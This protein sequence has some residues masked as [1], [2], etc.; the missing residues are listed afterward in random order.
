MVLKNIVFQLIKILSWIFIT[1]LTLL[2]IHNALQYFRYDTSYGILGESSAKDSAFYL[3]LF[4][5]HLLAGTLC[6]LTPLFQF[7]IRVKAKT[8][9]LHRFIGHV[10]TWSTLI[11]VVPTGLYIALFAKG[12]T[13]TQIGFIA[14][15]LLAGVFTWLGYQAGRK[16]NI[17]A[18][19][20]WMMRS[21]GAVSIV[22]TFRLLHVVFFHLRLPY[23]T[24]YEA[25][26]WIGIV[27][28]LLLVELLIERI[29]SKRKRSLNP[30]LS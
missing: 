15:G 3:S 5:T 22:L 14:Q 23:Q 18:H 2:L 16:R 20:K 25:S 6:I 27:L 19:I 21:Y 24:N 7:L 11:I 28:N 1:L 26:Q 9:T 4:Y 29:T 13:I 8:T 17:D 10:Y 30:M 12:G